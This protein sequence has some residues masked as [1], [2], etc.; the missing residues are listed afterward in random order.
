MGMRD[1]HLKVMR[2]NA[3]ELR[4]LIVNNNR[5]KS[6]SSQ[7][8]RELTKCPKRVKNDTERLGIQDNGTKLS[9]GVS[10]RI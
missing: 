1:L 5:V 8:V 2:L 7:L 4:I 10:D 9:H 6:R 3:Q